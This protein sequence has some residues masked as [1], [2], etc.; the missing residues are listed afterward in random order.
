M[1]DDKAQEAI[2]EAYERTIL[3]EKIDPKSFWKSWNKNFLAIKKLLQ[4]SLKNYE[5]MDDAIG[6]S[7]IQKDVDRTYKELLQALDNMDQEFNAAMPAYHDMFK[8]MGK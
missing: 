7:S 3:N 6:G 4:N 5:A 8:E 1:I 2:M